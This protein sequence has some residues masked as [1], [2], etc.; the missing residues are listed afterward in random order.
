MEAE[1]RARAGGRALPALLFLLLVL[2][3][4]ADPL[5]ARRN[6]TGRDL[7]TYQLPIEKSV[8]DAYARGRLPVWI[9]GISG[10]RPLL[11]NPNPGAFYPLRP[12]LALFP[13]PLAM[14]L[15]PVLHWVLAGVGMLLLLDSLASSRAAAWAGAA[16]YVFSGVG[17]SEVFYPYL[18][19]MALLP[20]ILWAVRRAASGAP[21][22]IVVLAL[23]LGLDLLAGET[24]TIALALACGLIWIL[25]EIEQ[26][27]R[28]RAARALALS[29]LLGSLLAAPQIV[30]AALWI[31]QSA[32]AVTGMNL[33]EATYFSIS[34]WRLA[35]LVIPYPFGATWEPGKDS[36]WGSAVLHDKA[37]GL[38]ATLYPGAFATIALA[39]GRR[40]PAEGRRFA[41]ALFWGALAACVLPSLIPPALSRFPS[42]LPLRYPEKFAVALVLAMA[43]LTAVAFDRWRAS[44]PRLE[45]VLGVGAA[46]AGLAAAAALVP[47][48]FGRLAIRLI[49]GQ[50]YWEKTAGERLAWA[51]AEAG[52]L[53]MA[54]AI[55]IVLLGRSGRV[56]LLTSLLLVTAV[57]L[58][59]NRR[60]ARAD[61]EEQVLGSTPFARFL[62]RRD[63]GGEYRTLGESLFLPPSAL[64]AKAVGSDVGLA[65]LPRRRWYEYVP[66]LW[67]RGTVLNIDFDAGDLSRMESLRRLSRIAAR[68]R[69]SE[70]FFGSLSL[71]WGVRFRDQPSLPG[72]RRVGGD[73]I[74]DWDEHACADPDIRLARS[75][76]EEAGPVPALNALPRL[77]RGEIVVE[78]GAIRRGVARPGQ[79][80]ILEKTPERV[81][82]ETDAP[83]R[84]WLFLLRGFWTYRSVLVDGKE[85]EVRPAQL[86]FSA[87]SLP[88]GAHRVDWRERVPGGAL[89]RWGPVLFLLV[90][91]LLLAGRRRGA[92]VN[93]S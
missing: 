55:A 28:A 18:P 6:F 52:L 35:E 33:E 14:R 69:D 34:P 30:A 83:D 8:H 62:Q 51:L 76:R 44:R 46:L 10:G 40:W 72:F 2:A 68:F 4:Y 54:A 87:V 49:G 48:P 90:A 71:R 60:I 27:R 80:R 92:R 59:A 32:R 85:T 25:L 38:F 77:A 78:S 17:V 47:Q 22:K 37:M 26:P 43:M 67:D 70:P 1:G 65:D 21:G 15:F 84:T 12:L 74:Q 29:A 61:R 31:P 89:S 36:T 19:G 9:S 63:P 7:P 50:P 75:W 79:V 93:A 45:W 86:A 88:A 11:P 73:A 58:L 16:T 66:V 13:F 5:F 82:L 57:P 91:G 64:E 24:F 81:L 42:P 23:L 3:V 53:W 41:R 56:A 20:W 39:A